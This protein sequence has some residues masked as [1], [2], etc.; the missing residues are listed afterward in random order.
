MVVKLQALAPSYAD[1]PQPRMNR[2]GIVYAKLL[3]DLPGIF[4]SEI[5]AKC[6]GLLH[7]LAIL[8]AIK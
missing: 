2:F 1:R 4:A 6:S 8:I 7:F 5:Y 3:H